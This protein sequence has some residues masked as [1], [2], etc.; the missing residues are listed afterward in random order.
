MPRRRSKTAR[1]A[2][3][4][5]RTL[6][7]AATL[8]KRVDE[9][10]QP[11]ALVIGWIGIAALAGRLVLA[12]RPQDEWPLGMTRP[13]LPVYATVALDAASLLGWTFMQEDQ[14]RIE[15]RVGRTAALW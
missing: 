6:E 8:P 7:A 12:T 2:S 15:R 4:V 14:R 9:R 13:R 1:A 10:L 5:G 11:V 3:R